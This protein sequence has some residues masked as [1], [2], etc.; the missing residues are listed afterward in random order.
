MWGSPWQHGPLPEA[1]LWEGT[2][3]ATEAM[4]PEISGPHYL[5]YIL[6]G[7]A[8]RRHALSPW[9]GSQLEEGTGD[10][11]GPPRT[12]LPRSHQLYHRNL[13]QAWE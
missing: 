3:L 5:K 8:L 4:G 11:K 7:Q 10:S 6:E 9:R 12:F 13:Q 2:H 1:G